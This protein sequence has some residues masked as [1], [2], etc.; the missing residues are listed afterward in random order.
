M[1]LS[2]TCQSRGRLIPCKS[3]GPVCIINSGE[4]QLI[5]EDMRAI[6]E[7]QHLCFA[8]TVSPDGRPN[9]SPKGTIRVWDEAHVF[10]CDIASPN[11]RSNLERN[12]WIELN[13]VDPLSRRGY[14]FLGK[15]TL[16]RDDDVYRQANQ[17]IF[18]EEGALYPV[19]AVILIRVE[20][21]LPLYSPGYLHVNDEY[22]MRKM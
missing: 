19:H 17:R 4:P 11:T 3:S 9:L 5:N 22:G 1:L 13:I 2:S 7:G 8:A 21:A 20:Q 10:F 18:A 14:R 16:H 12:P 6:I 15:A